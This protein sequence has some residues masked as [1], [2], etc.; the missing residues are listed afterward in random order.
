MHNKIV[1]QLNPQILEFVGKAP[2]RH[3]SLVEKNKLRL[4]G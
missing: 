4:Q 3:Q 1:A 2:L